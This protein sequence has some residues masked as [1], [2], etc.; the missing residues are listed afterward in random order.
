MQSRTSLL[1]YTIGGNF[2]YVGWNISSLLHYRRKLP[3]CRAKHLYSPSLQEETSYMQS[4]NLY[5]LTL[6]EETP[7]MQSG[8]YLL[9]FTIGGNALYVEWNISTLLHYRRKLPICRLQSKTFLLSY[10][11]GG[12]FLYVEWN[13]STLLHYRRKLPTVHICRMEH[14]YSPS[15]QEETSYMQSGHLYSPTFQEETLYMQN[16]TSLQI[17]SYTTVQ[18]KMKLPICRAEHLYIYFPTL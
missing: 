1:S 5:S 7:Y 8:T 4:G 11:I 16:G 3:I 17:L 14:L 6:Q 9:S 10:T 2:L 15:L 18:Y 13:I 12:N